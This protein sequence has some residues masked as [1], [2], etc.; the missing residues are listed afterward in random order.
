M[1]L[2]VLPGDRKSEQRW[3]ALWRGLGVTHADPALRQELLAHYAQP[4]RRYH[5]LHHLDACLEHFDRVREQAT[6]P[7]EV[8]MALW[9]HDAVYEVPGADNELRSAHW[10]RDALHKAG[11]AEEVAERVHALVM[12]TRHDVAPKTKDQGLLLDVDLAILGAEE[13]LFEVYEVQIREEYAAVPRDAVQAN[14]RRILQGFLN[15]EW[16]FNTAS[17][18]AC[19][20]QSARNNLQRSIAALEEN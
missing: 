14:R 18:R 17:F 10:A 15:R 9:F 16:I 12:A 6:H 4:Q 11:V 5:A 20:E 7:A 1:K 8:E 2:P 3:L 13:S 19:F